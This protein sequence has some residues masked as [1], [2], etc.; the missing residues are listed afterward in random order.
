MPVSGAGGTLGGAAGSGG[1]LADAGAGA[2]LPGLVDGCVDLDQNAVGDC[3]ETLVTNAVFATDVDGW[4]VGSTPLLK[5]SDQNRAADTPSGS[6]LLSFETDPV[7]MDGLAE[8]AA[9]QCLPI[10]GGTKLVLRANAYIKPEQ[11]EGLA[12]LGVWFYEQGDCSGPALTPFV[13]VRAETD[14]WLTL[15]GS[16][17]APANAASMVVR[18]TVGK[19]QRQKAFEV[20]FD[21]VLVRAK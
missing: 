21:N 12:G 17:D 5:W 16:S 2:A 15:S 20:V 14:T 8:S 7:D 6:A 9:A 13:V 11:G 19:P 10:S 4:N 3:T 18:L 1:S